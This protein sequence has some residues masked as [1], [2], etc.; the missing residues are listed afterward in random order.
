MPTAQQEKH[1][2]DKKSGLKRLNH[3]VPEKLYNQIADLSKE[4]RLDITDLVRLGLGLAMLA[5]REAQK[6]NKLIVTDMDGVPLKELV[7]PPGL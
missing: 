2:P 4:T 5:I 3:I 7:L 1:S 6:G